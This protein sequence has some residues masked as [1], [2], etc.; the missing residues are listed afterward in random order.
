MKARIE[1]IDTTCPE[2]GCPHVA[3]FR[4]LL[5]TGD[6]GIYCRHHAEELKKE[7]DDVEDDPEEMGG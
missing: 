1:P 7:L 2:E 4:V 5:G 6:H 3:L